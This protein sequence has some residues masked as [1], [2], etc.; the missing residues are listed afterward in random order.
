MLD[1]GS[2]KVGD[3]VDKNFNVKNI[4]LYK[5]KI[6]FVIKKK[7]YKESF[8]IESMEFELD[9]NA[10]KDVLV[11][12]SSLKEVKL[13][14]N[15]NTTDIF[16]EILEGKT[17]ETHR[18][19]PINVNVNSVFSAYSVVPLKNMNFGPIQFN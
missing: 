4:G 3:F 13:K 17:M 7:L 14:T 11:R 15:S 8:K 16:M 1:F 5:V 10:N 2:L 18:S 6:S 19:V 12:F 9:P